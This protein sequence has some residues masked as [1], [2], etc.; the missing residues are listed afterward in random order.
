MCTVYTNYA[1]TYLHAHYVRYV[2]ISTYLLHV[3]HLSMIR[4]RG[5]FQLCA[6]TCELTSPPSSVCACVT[7][8]GMPVPLHRGAAP[9][10]RY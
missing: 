8:I 4:I 10:P 9:I 5:R 1:N 2:C 7:A 6:G 3:F